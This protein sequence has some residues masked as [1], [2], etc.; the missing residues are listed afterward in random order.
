[1]QGEGAHCLSLDIRAVKSSEIHDI[2]TKDGIFW[3]RSRIYGSFLIELPNLP[4]L[5]VW[6]VVTVQEMVEDLS[7][8]AVLNWNQL[9]KLRETLMDQEFVIYSKL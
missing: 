3:L 9:T 4:E 7:G 2:V 1:M 5:V 8:V 6:E